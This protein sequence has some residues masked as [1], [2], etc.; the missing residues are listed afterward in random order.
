MKC[1][2]EL[3]NY[4]KAIKNNE[5]RIRG[6]AAALK[7]SGD[8]KVYEDALAYDV[9]RWYWTVT[10]NESSYAGC[11]YKYDCNDNHVLTLAKTGLKKAG[12]I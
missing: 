6:Y 8:F 9:F 3:E 1:Q 7:E 4:L 12:I 5:K 11:Y 10:Y 2:A